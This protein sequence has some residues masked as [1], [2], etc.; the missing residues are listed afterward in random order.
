MGTSLTKSRVM[1]EN[2]AIREK[3]TENAPIW[4]D[5]GHGKCVLCSVMSVSDR[6]PVFSSTSWWYHFSTVRLWQAQGD[7]MNRICKTEILVLGAWWWHEAWWWWPVTTWYSWGAL[8]RWWHWAP[9][10][11]R[12]EQRRERGERERSQFGEKSVGWFPC[13][14]RV[15][16]P[17]APNLTSTGLCF[18]SLWSEE[19]LRHTRPGLHQALLSW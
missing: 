3:L 14:S 19:Q 2:V 17:W 8:A 6:S 16:P 9:C 10:D 15:S 4:L 13:L 5:P 1:R 18:R 7:L 11:G 12:G